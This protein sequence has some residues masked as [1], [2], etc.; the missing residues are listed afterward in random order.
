MSFYSF[1]Y[2]K[3]FLHE[4]SAPL[5]IVPPT[6]PLFLLL[7]LH[8][9]H[10]VFI[11]PLLSFYYLGARQ[12]TVQLGRLFQEGKRGAERRSDGK[13]KEKEKTDVNYEVV[14]VRNA[15]KRG[16]TGHAHHT[17]TQQQLEEAPRPPTK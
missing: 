3:T 9:T 10:P 8:L 1:A 11:G 6:T 4:T 2:S 5:G 17:N 16:V 15:G 12:S 7:I 14:T 13:E